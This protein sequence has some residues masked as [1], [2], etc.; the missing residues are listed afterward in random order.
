MVRDY[1]PPE[2]LVPGLIHAGSINGIGGRP[3]IGKTPFLMQLG[4]SMARGE[5]WCEGAK[6]SKKVG[7]L[8]L[9]LER[10]EHNLYNQL[11]VQLD[12]DPAPP[13]FYVQWGWP[14]LD[15]PGCTQ[16]GNWL[17]AHPTV[18]VV[19]VDPWAL[20]RP[21]A[22]KKDG[23]NAYFEDYEDIKRLRKLSNTLGVA[24]LLSI[25]TNQTKKPMDMAAAFY[26][27]TGF[28]GALDFCGVLRKKN[29]VPDLWGQGTWVG[30]FWWTMS[31]D[32]PVWQRVGKAED[33]V[34]KTSDVQ[35]YILDKWWEDHCDEDESAPPPPID[36]N[37][38]FA[39]CD[40]KVLAPK[41][42]SAKAPEMAFRRAL[43]DLVE[44]GRVQRDDDKLTY[45]RQ[46]EH[47]EQTA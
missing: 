42:K 47:L 40:P 8:H 46:T 6:A 2:E 35:D 31:Y 15:T 22:G 27:N 11:K 26:G 29:G 37:V 16:L 24:F 19:T 43:Q 30:E 33:P 12:G 41:G 20:V 3:R 14:K 18:K 1:S 32:R 5:P 38:L 44:K 4:L 21:T 34:Q 39:R 17:Q 25:H 9:G 7:V 45:C 23:V 10:G 36:K 13:D 28:V